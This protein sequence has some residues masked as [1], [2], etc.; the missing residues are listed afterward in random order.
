MKP[1]ALHARQQQQKNQCNQLLQLNLKLARLGIRVDGRGAKSSSLSDL[2]RTFLRVARDSFGTQ[3]FLSQT[4]E[5]CDMK[6]GSETALDYINAPLIEVEKKGHTKA[7]NLPR[8][9]LS[10]YKS[11]KMAN[12]VLRFKHTQVCVCLIY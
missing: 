2:F 12:Y 4:E 1:P 10:Y 11:R 6:Q 8:K 7:G 3:L 9:N 5:T